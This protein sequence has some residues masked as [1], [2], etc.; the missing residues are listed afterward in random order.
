G[1]DAQ[2]ARQARLRRAQLG[3]ELAVP[4]QHLPRVQQVALARRGQPDAVAR[5]GEQRHPER[6]L[7]LLHLAAEPRLG[8]PQLG[9]GER[10]AAAF[11]NPQEALKLLDVHRLLLAQR[12]TL[13][14]RYTTVAWRLSPRY[15]SCML[16]MAG[17]G[18]TPSHLAIIASVRV[19][20]GTTS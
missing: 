14:R 1:G 20:H 3:E 7:Q 4:R 17:R 19:V 9:R 18:A 12:A 5:A 13:R 6:A 8:D 16:A 15:A 11:G 2:L 10:Q